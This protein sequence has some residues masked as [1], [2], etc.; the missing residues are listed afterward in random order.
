[1]ERSTKSQGDNRA[2]PKITHRTRKGPASVSPW[3]KNVRLQP[4][5][6]FRGTPFLSTWL[7]RERRMRSSRCVGDVILAFSSQRT[8]SKNV[9]SLPSF[10]L[11][12]T[13]QD[14]SSFHSRRRPKGLKGNFQ[15]QYFSPG[16]SG[17]ND[18]QG[19][20]SKGNS[21]LKERSLRMPGFLENASMGQSPPTNPGHWTYSL[22]QYQSVE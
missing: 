17:S 2:V 13:Q 4:L 6:N 22:D 3:T 5:L 15:S 20:L 11:K 1:M 19:Q 21:T 16:R 14:S 9:T 18:C 8:P 10:F 12:L 7:E